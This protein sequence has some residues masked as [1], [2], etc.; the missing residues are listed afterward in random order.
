MSQP[1]WHAEHSV[2]SRGRHVLWLVLSGV[3][4]GPAKITKAMG[5]LS[6]AFGAHFLLG[7]EGT[8][9]RSIPGIEAVGTEARKD[10]FGDKL[11]FGC[12][13]G[14]ETVKCC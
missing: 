9:G 2:C 11:A 13:F 14:N 6:H 7:S 8:Q 3:L 5:P 10:I 4:Q 1:A 12:G